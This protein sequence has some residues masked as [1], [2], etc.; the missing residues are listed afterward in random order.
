MAKRKPLAFDNT[1]LAENLQKSA[2][3]GIDAFFS[4]LSPTPLPETSKPDVSDTEPVVKPE[5][6]NTSTINK[7][8]IQIPQKHKK[9]VPSNRDTTIPRHHD[10]TVSRYHDTSIGL[11]RKA[12]KEFGKEAATHRFTMEEKRAVA[13]LIFT[14]KSQGIRTSENEIARIAINFIIADFN[15]NGENSILDKVMKA[16]QE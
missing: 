11:L 8:K 1:E 9:K 7:P 12:V 3:K 2:A 4:P 6:S 5:P 16:L 14:Y 13:N 15:E 10:T